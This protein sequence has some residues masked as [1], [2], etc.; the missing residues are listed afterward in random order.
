MDFNQEVKDLV[1]NDY[2]ILYKTY[3]PQTKTNSIRN[4]DIEEFINF[5]SRIKDIT[6]KLA[7]S[8]M[9]VESIF[10]NYKP[11]LDILSNS[12]ENHISDYKD[13]STLSIFIRNDIKQYLNNMNNY[14]NF[15]W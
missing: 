1:S 3:D 10:N 11:E 8:S 5:R 12:F 6:E 15:I 7:T 9:S 4:M 13:F 2:Q 14:A